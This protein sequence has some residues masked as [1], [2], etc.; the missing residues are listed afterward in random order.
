VS[1]DFVD[2][3]TLGI[4]TKTMLQVT[5]DLEKAELAGKDSEWALGA[6]R[7]MLAA[8]TSRFELLFPK[9]GDWELNKL[10]NVVSVRDSKLQKLLSTSGL[11]YR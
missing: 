8:R 3:A 2:L 1:A 4:P 11:L 9:P 6:Y 10:F 7:D 5:S